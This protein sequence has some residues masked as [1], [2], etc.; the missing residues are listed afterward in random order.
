ME[1]LLIFDIP[2]IREACATHNKENADEIKRARIA[3]RQLFNKFPII[4]EACAKADETK[5]NS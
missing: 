4:G 5:N 2:I 3:N 1:K